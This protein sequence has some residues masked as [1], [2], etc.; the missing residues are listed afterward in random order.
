MTE[1]I[2]ITQA[3]AW[4]KV[5]THLLDAPVV[6]ARGLQAREAEGPVHVR[7][8]YPD[9][10]FVDSTSREFNHAITALEGLSLVGQCSVPELQT[11]RV[12]AMASFQNRSVFRGAYGPRI[13]GALDDVVSLLKRD[14]DSRQA[15]L[16][17]YDA[18]R[19]LGRSDVGFKSGDVPCTLN[20]QFLLRDTYR[21]KD[22]A[23]DLPHHTRLC[24]WVTM[25][26]NDAWL[27]LPYD[28]G[29]F[30]VLQ[31]AVAQA[32]GV[33]SGWYTHSAGS[34]HLYQ[35]DWERAAKIEESQVGTGPGSVT[36][37]G[38]GSIT[39]TAE[40]CR[41]ILLGQGQTHLTTL[42]GLEAWL[43]RQVTR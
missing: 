7:V 12:K 35:K 9:S 8:E 18:R 26:S 37:G 19:D 40:R 22:S 10:G 24:M 30:S 14:P 3:E 41:R 42:T 17:M 31:M 16:T 38:D 4:S 1:I 36:F 28:L 15:V 21:T 34:M 20:I 11:D 6:S 13:E 2:A 39:D 33:E 5:I 43:I 27:G 23:P 25:R 29:Q 32:L